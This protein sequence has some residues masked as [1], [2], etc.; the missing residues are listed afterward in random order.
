MNQPDV[1]PATS[2][3]NGDSGN[4]PASA[5]GAAPIRDEAGPSSG[6]SEVS[7][8][9]GSNDPLTSVARDWHDMIINSNN[10]MIGAALTIHGD[11]YFLADAGIGNYLGISNP[12]NQSITIDGSMNPINGQVNIVLNFRTPIDYDDESGFVKYPLGGFLPIAMFS[13]VY[14]VHVVTNSFKQGRFTQTLDI[15]RMRNQDLTLS[16]I[17]GALVS[18][19]TGAKEAL[20]KAIGVGTEENRMGEPT[21]TGQPNGGDAP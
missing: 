3:N 1:S 5:E 18:A 8:G 17:K 6:N 14:Q 9:G 12:A 2:T 10:D 16:N 21:Q 20:G 7:G 4:E 15:T 11:P 19:F 13:G